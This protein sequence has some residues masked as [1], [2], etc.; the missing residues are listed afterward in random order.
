MEI[1]GIAITLALIVPIALFVYIFGFLCDREETR[2]RA[3]EIIIG[4]QPATE[5]QLDKYIKR[6]QTA[7]AGLLSKNEVD[8]GRIARL[9][10]IRDEMV[11]P[12]KLKTQ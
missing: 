2:A 3:D 9:R 1:S 10:D 7:N 12:H 8:L 4:I 11:T 6:L 5:K